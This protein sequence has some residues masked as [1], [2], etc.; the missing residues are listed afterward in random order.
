[1]HDVW[2]PLVETDPQRF[3]DLIFSVSRPDERRTHYPSAADALLGEIV[4]Y[5]T[6]VEEAGVPDL[7]AFYRWCLDAIPVEIRRSIAEHVRRMRQHPAVVTI[8]AYLP[9][10]MAETDR[11]IVST[12]SIDW[13]SEGEVSAGDPMSRP[14]DLINLILAGEPANPGAVFGG[15]LHLGDPRVCGLLWPVRQTLRDEDANEAVK[16][17]T[18][19]LSSATIEFVLSWMESIPADGSSALFGILASNLALQ[20][21]HLTTPYVFTGE[22]PFPFVNVPEEARR[23]MVKPVPIAVYTE[24]VAPRFRALEAA[25]PTPKVMT[26]VLRMW[27]IT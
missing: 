20:R 3:H 24:A 27:G 10:I 21:R 8:N 23:A 4:R 7:R 1:M 15:L 25:E 26:E 18:G 22:R 14:R 6:L 2:T 9:F 17:V 13:S 16:C 11:L 12:A 5:G 19:F